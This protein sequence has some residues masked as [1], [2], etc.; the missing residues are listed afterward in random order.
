MRRRRAAFAAAF[1]CGSRRGQSPAPPVPPSLDRSKRLGEDPE[2]IPPSPKNFF[3]FFVY[4][5]GGTRYNGVYTMNK[6][7]Q[8][9]K[10][11]AKVAAIEDKNW[12]APMTKGI[13]SIDF[14][15]N[16]IFKPTKKGNPY[17]KSKTY[18]KR[19]G[20]NTRGWTNAEAY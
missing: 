3:H 18:L 10:E 1:F 2:G 20:V 15:D 9:T 17:L 14:R 16:G 12:S 6:S 19:P 5:P 4:I 8:T 13:R 7:T 11:L